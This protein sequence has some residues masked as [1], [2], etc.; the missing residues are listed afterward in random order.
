M[1]LLTIVENAIKHGIAHLKNGGVLTLN[2]KI[3]NNMVIIDVINPYQPDL[4]KSGTKVGLKNLTQRIDLIFGKQGKLSQE[5]EHDTFHVNMSL[6]YEP[7]KN[8]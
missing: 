8:G 7:I 2:T 6:P 3:E 5:T 1:G 4:V